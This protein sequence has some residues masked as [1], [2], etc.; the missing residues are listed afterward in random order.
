MYKLPSHFQ[1]GWINNPRSISA[2]P[3]IEVCSFQCLL[4]LVSDFSF[5]KLRI[6]YPKGSSTKYVGGTFYRNSWMEEREWQQCFTWQQTS[7]PSFTQYQL[8]ASK[9][10]KHRLEGFIICI[11]DGCDKI[12]VS[13]PCCLDLQAI[14]RF[15]IS[16]MR[17]FRIYS[18]PTLILIWRFTENIQRGVQM[19]P[20]LFLPLCTLQSHAY[21]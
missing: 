2:E 5:L 16:L 13:S 4:S 1:Q 17:I 6:L 8:L 15:A 9:H 19:N 11:P 18:F 12:K 14:P 21:T 20:D 10:W 3:T 7:T